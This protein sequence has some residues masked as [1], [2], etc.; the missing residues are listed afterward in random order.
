MENKMTFH[1]NGREFFGIWIVN[2]IL[3]L[4]TLGIYSAWAKVRTK[5]YFYGNTEL[6]GDR[7]DYHA[8]PKQILIGRAIAVTA[9]VIWFLSGHFSPLFSSILFI[10]G[11]AVMPWL[12]RN[13]ARFNARMTSYR[14]VRLNFTGTLM[15]AY[16]AIL[17]RGVLLILTIIVF[18]TFAT[19][20]TSGFI[21]FLFVVGGLTSVL[22][23][24]AWMMK[25]IASYFANG[26]GYGKL[27]F[28]ATLSTGF[29]V[30][31]YIWAVFI[32]ILASIG[33]LA[34]GALFVVVSGQF[35]SLPDIGSAELSTFNIEHIATAL[36]AM[37]IMVLMYF[38]L[39]ASMLV[40][41]AFIHTRTR[42]H[43]FSQMMV[44]DSEDYRLSSRMN[45]A[46]YTLLVTTNF[47]MQVFTLG[48]A[49]PWVMVRTARYVLS[50]TAVHG[51]LDALSVYE[52]ENGAKSAVGDEM[53]QVFD[54]DIG[55]S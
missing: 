23:M 41:T 43:V 55:I 29:F 37:S 20:P 50:V 26:Y 30:R 46:D 28:D 19:A 53:S 14:N 38:M 5:K 2:I 17:G 48:L 32:W 11:L 27:K 25:G 15:G 1:G 7:F 34:I 35:F 47:F 9:F 31:T 18:V 52:D 13:N 16:A 21:T 10:L 22:V 45:T 40:V 39:F 3:S 54:L 42:N 24:F 33:V 12:A 51:D 6:A 4:L 44:G 49:R 36:G 8:T